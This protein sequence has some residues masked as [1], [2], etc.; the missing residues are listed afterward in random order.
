[1]KDV[2]KGVYE[3]CKN[4]NLGTYKLPEYDA[5]MTMAT[6]DED[7]DPIPSSHKLIH[8]IKDHMRAWRV[9]KSRHIDLM[10]NAHKNQVEKRARDE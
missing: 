10:I 8:A 3:S 6:F 1:M 5:L 4:G 2:R 7:N 9:K